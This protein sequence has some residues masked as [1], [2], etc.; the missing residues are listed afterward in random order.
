MYVLY[1]QRQCGEYAYVIHAFSFDMQL[2][3]KHNRVYT[4]IVCAAVTPLSP[5]C[6]K[7]H[8]LTPSHLYSHSLTR[9]LN[10]TPSISL[11]SHTHSHSLITPSPP[12]DSCKQLSTITTPTSPNAAFTLPT[13]ATTSPRRS[14]PISRPRVPSI[15][16]PKPPPQ[17][18]TV[19]NY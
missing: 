14:A 1:I 13:P 18:T 2:A 16:K 7:A 11:S 5:C 3:C 9:T 10:L 8:P 17:A 15:S 12:H 4:C 19:R 6:P